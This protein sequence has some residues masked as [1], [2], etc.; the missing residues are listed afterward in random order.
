MLLISSLAHTIVQLAR[1]AFWRC[2]WLLLLEMIDLSVR[3]VL[4]SHWHMH[5][6]HRFVRA[7][8]CGLRLR[9]R[10]LRL[11][12]IELSVEFVR[13]HLVAAYFRGLLS[14]VRVFVSLVVSC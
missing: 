11:L 7:Q 6:S 10:L 2:E 5:G 14:V 4:L 12:F 13:P 9:A 1:K 3:V 8:C